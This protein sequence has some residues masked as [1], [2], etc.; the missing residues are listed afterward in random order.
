MIIFVIVLLILLGL[1]L[2]LLELLVLPGITFA[3]LGG[4][5]MIGFG[6]Y[7]SYD[8][9]G[10]FYGHVTSVGT[11]FIGIITV[12]YALKSKTWNR[13]KLNAEIDSKVEKL[14]EAK[15]QIGD[16]G[17]CISR[18]APMGKIRVENQTVE[19]K[20]LGTYIDEKTEVEIV[21]IKDQT[22]I[23]KPL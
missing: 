5:L 2:L 3:A 22:V 11:L 19:A 9:F 16:K 10:V 14:D 21:D 17:L 20:S 7:F 8:Q 12:V 23:V 4:I 6:I 13:I 1:L 18:L 15:V